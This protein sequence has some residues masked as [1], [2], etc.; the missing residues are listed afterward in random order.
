MKV[1]FKLFLGVISRNH[2]KYR[3]PLAIMPTVFLTPTVGISWIDRRTRSYLLVVVVVVVVVGVMIVADRRL[4]VLN[5]FETLPLGLV[6]NEF[7]YRSLGF[8]R[9]SCVPNCA[10]ACWPFGAVSLLVEV[11]VG[12]FF[13]WGVAIPDAC[14]F[15]ARSLVT[16]VI[17]VDDS[18][19]AWKI[20]WRNL[21]KNKIFAVIP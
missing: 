1:S 18:V 3:I 10:A 17:C 15:S 8:V 2:S 11:E 19:R 7:L 16:A 13:F 9:V 5:I 20:Y 6:Y 12:V 4:V 14:A 21:R